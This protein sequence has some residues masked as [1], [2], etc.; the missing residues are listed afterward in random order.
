MMLW[1]IPVFWLIRDFETVVDNLERL[2]GRSG[3]AVRWAAV[4]SLLLWPVAMII[5]MMWGDDE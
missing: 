3:A 2:T 4:L 1:V 5:E